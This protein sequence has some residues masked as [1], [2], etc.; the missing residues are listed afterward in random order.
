M[1]KTSDMAIEQQTRDEAAR[2]NERARE[3]G[4][5]LA[6]ALRRVMRFALP[7]TYLD[8]EDFNFAR[9]TLRKLEP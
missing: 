5:E 7:I 9:A 8:T 3:I 2:E 1:S 4:P 6:K